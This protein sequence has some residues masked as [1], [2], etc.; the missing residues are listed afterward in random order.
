MHIDSVKIYPGECFKVDCGI[1]YTLK[2]KKYACEEV[3]QYIYIYIYIYI[4]IYIYIYKHFDAMQNVI[5]K[6]TCTYQTISS[7]VIMESDIQTKQ[8]LFIGSQ[9]N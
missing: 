7:D 1:K 3:C 9:S 8:I 6:H 5:Q 4:H 2:I